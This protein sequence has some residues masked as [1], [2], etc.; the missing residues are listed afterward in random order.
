[1]YNEIKQAM[2]DLM[3]RNT[4]CSYIITDGDE[5]IY[6]KNVLA[7]N[8]YMKTYELSKAASK[9]MY[10]YMAPCNQQKAAA[11]VFEIEDGAVRLSGVVIKKIPLAG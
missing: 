4:I 8:A 2:D 9:N 5:E 7:T 3:Q 10:C 1:M 6:M 11:P